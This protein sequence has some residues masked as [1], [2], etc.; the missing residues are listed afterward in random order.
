MK[1]QNQITVVNNMLKVQRAGVDLPFLVPCAC[2]QEL[3]ELEFSQ[4]EF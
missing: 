4:S 1:V 2:L 3:E